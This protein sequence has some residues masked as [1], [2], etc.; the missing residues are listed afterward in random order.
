[1]IIADNI[2]DSEER[3]NLCLSVL[4]IPGNPRLFASVM[5][6]SSHSSTTIESSN[7]SNYMPDFL[8]GVLANP[9]CNFDMDASSNLAID[10][11]SFLIIPSLSNL[12]ALD[13]FLQDDFPT[14]AINTI[15]LWVGIFLSTIPLVLVVYFLLLSCPLA[16]S[17]LPTISLAL[18]VR[19]FLLSRPL[20]IPF[21]TIP[22][23]LVYFLL[24]HLLA[25]PSMI[26]RLYAIL[27]CQ[28]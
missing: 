15:L 1:M 13:R 14:L 8:A 7:R 19:F 21:T 11:V 5:S 2:S 12:P 27:A 17:Q 10:P 18:V 20:A 6:G 24:S 22:L 28:E 23:V 26:G 25:I 16:I 9:F 3:G 4:D